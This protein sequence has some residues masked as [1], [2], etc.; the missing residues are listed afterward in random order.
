[1]NVVA[2]GPKLLNK[3]ANVYKLINNIYPKCSLNKPITVNNIVNATNPI[4]YIVFLPHLSTNKTV[5]Q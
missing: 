5:N 2:L 1:M 3:L 4:I